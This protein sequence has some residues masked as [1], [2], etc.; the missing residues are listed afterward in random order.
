MYGHTIGASV[1]LGYL[2]QPQGVADH[3]VMS[4]EY[5]IAIAEQRVAAR[6]SISPMYDPKG[7][8]PRQ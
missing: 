6:A 8:R 4:G 2:S 3:F 7:L 1:A 5:E